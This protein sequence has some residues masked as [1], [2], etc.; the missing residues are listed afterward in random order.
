M[1]A[2]KMQKR[3]YAWKLATTVNIYFVCLFVY[4][5]IRVHLLN[6]IFAAKIVSS[7]DSIS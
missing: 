3:R 2:D 5:G 1:Q 7:L 6:V 4:L